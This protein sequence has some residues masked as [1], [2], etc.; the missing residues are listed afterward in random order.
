MV[1]S[2]LSVWTGDPLYGKGIYHWASSSTENPAC[3]V[4]P[5]TPLDVGEIVRRSSDFVQRASLTVV[6]PFR[7]QL[8]VIDATKTPFAVSIRALNVIPD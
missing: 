5:G 1:E 2:G 7:Q 3:V 4:E 6:H 8:K